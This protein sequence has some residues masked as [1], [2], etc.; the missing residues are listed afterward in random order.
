M[1]T[2]LADILDEIPTEGLSLEAL[3]STASRALFEL[4]INS[5]DARTSAS[6]D[7]R[8]LRF[9]QTLGILPKPAYEGRRAVYA[10]TH[11]VRA[12]AAKQLQ[13]EGHSLAQIQSVLPVQS[14]DAL[15]QALTLALGI[16]RHATRPSAS[17]EAITF[18]KNHSPPSPSFVPV[19][20]SPCVEELRTFTLTPGAT[21]ILDPR[22]VALPEQ[23][24]AVLGTLA[25]AH[26]STA[27]RSDPRSSQSSRP[28]T[29]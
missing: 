16:P 4:G 28:S 29:H 5:D 27:D 3:T 19:P 14:D 10:M 13:A 15:V 7:V 12:L 23:L 17:L 25:R 6:I 11:L 26:L 20:A 9:Y 1:S 24:A 8:T 21:L 22:I 2:A 18:E